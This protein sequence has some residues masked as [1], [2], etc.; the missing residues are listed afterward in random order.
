MMAVTCTR[1]FGVSRHLLLLLTC[2]TA[3]R[4]AL[5]GQSLKLVFAGDIMVHDRQLRAAGQADGSYDFS[6]SFRYVAPLL[7]EAD[8]AIGNLELTLPGHK[9]YAGYPHFRAPDTLAGTL[10]EAGFDVL[11]TANNHSNDS[12]RRGIWRT[13]EALAKRSLYYTGTFADTL[14]RDTTYP[15]LLQ[16]QGY[17]LALLNYT[18]GTNDPHVPAPCFVNV[19]DTVQIK[20]DLAKARRLNPDLIIAYMHWGHEYHLDENEEQHQLAHQLFQWG[21]DIIIGAHP[22]VIQPVRIL[23]DYREG[24]LRHGLV[25]YSLG[26]FI[27]GQIKE[28]T[29]LGLLLE[30]ELQRHPVTRAVAFRHHY[31]PV[32]RHRGYTATGRRTFTIIPVSAFAQKG[33]EVL[34]SPDRRAMLTVTRRLRKHLRRFNSSERVVSLSLWKNE[35]MP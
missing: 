12:G 27:S 22:H 30:I 16:H 33:Q 2:L 21:A 11:V 7:Q 25:A 28:N 24:Q 34:S 15:L 13:L 5:P 23:H 18:Y 19:I 3:G 1:L 14:E 20:Q 6:S 35:K 31:I 32:W 29:D 17:R 8:L 10:K 26:N 9:P 4:T